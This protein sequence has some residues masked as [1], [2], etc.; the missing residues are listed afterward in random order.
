MARRALTAAAC[1]AL[2]ALGTWDLGGRELAAGPTMGSCL[3]DPGPCAGERVVEGGHR[4]PAAAG[5]AAFVGRGYRVE[6]GGLPGH[7][8]GGPLAQLSVEGT[9]EGEATIRVERWLLSPWGR[10]KTAVG[11]LA[12]VLASLW[13]VRFV[14][15]RAGRGRGG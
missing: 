11:A 14:A 5:P 9:W 2:L 13:G 12:L 3:R 15:V 6:L 7:V 10:L 8:R 4:F 1:L